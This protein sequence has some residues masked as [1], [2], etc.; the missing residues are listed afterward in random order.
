MN[1]MEFN[2]TTQYIVLALHPEK[3]RSMISHIRF[4]Y[5]LTGAV[6][7]D[8]LDNE[9]ISLSGTRLIPAFRK[10]V[11]PVHDMFAGKIEKSS[12]PRRIYF[13][14]R[15]LSRDSRF[16]FRETVISLIN[17]GMIRHERRFFLNIIPYNRYF[18]TDTR[19]RSTIIDEL[20]EVLLHGKPANRKQR[21]MLGLIKAS[22]S[23]RLL[24]RESGERWRLR[25]QCN[26]FLQSDIVSSEVE[27]A[28]RA[29]EA[30]IVTSV[31]AAIAAANASHF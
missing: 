23:Y 25:T 16:I 17:K 28:I 14:V 21:M 8:F 19:I 12:K 5:S 22:R 4:R 29:T 13:W 7:M 27:K 3:R 31:I 18:L 9:E 24:E 11:D 2:V 30:A 10:N 15:R 1:E 26:Q 6:L 20:R